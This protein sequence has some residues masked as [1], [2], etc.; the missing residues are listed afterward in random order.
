MAR[1]STSKRPAYGLVGGLHFSVIAA[2]L[3]MLQRIRLF[4]SYCAAQTQ[5]V[6]ND[7][8]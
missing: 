4:K 5:H 2:M 6:L 8:T 1:L 7:E 3:L